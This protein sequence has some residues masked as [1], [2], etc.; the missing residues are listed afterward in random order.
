MFFSRITVGLLLLSLITTLCACANLFDAARQGDD[1]A[2][3][4]MIDQG[5]DIE[6]KDESG[7]TAL[8]WAAA[9]NEMNTVRLLLEN[10]ANSGRKWVQGYCAI[11]AQQRC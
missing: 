6:V 9:S 4:V 8:M 11:I 1:A 3:H 10:R 5:A 7:M 2:L